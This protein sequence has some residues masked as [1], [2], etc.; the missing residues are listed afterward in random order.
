MSPQSVSPDM[1]LQNAQLVA[2]SRLDGRW[3]E[4]ALNCTIV[5]PCMLKSCCRPY[6]EPPYASGSDVDAGQLYQIMSVISS[7][8]FGSSHISFSDPHK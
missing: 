6:T 4:A 7:I 8:C 5:V 1:V 3:I 2:L